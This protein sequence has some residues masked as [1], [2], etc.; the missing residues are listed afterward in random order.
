MPGRTNRCLPNCPLDM[1]E[2]VQYP[3]LVKAAA[4]AAGAASAWH[5]PRRNCRQ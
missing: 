1:A 5:Y 2:K 3:V 4:G